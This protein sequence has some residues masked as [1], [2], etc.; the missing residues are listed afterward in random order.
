MILL[1]LVP[2]A[3]QCDALLITSLG[4]GLIKFS[5]CHFGNKP[6]SNITG[7]AHIPLGSQGKRENHQDKTKCR[8]AGFP[9]KPGCASTHTG[10]TRMHVHVLSKAQLRHKS[11]P[12]AGGKGAKHQF[13]SCTSNSI[14][15]LTPPAST[16]RTAK[17]PTQLPAEKRF[18]WSKP[19]PQPDQG[20]GKLGPGEE[21]QQ[22]C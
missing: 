15:K 18:T 17:I 11:H 16:V 4:L 5:I 9:P 14:T 10:D 22:G 7:Q 12:A 1:E 2:S 3:R 8:A 6:Q 13:S 20:R 19:G 21:G